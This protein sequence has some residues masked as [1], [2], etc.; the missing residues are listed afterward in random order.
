MKIVLYA[1]YQSRPF[2]PDTLDEIGLG[3]TEQCIIYLAYYLTLQPN[4]EVYVVGEVISGDYDNVKYRTTQEFKQEVKSVDT[5]IAASYIHYLKEFEDIEFKNSIFWVHNTDY[6]TW[7]NGQD[8][9]NHRELLT[10]PKL[11]TIICLTNWHKYKFVEQFPETFDRIEVI[12]NGIDRGHFVNV[13]PKLE[14]VNGKVFSNNFQY[15]HLKNSN[16]YVYTSHCERGLAKLLE[17]WPDIKQFN[18][19][20]ILKISTPEYGLEYYNLYFKELVDNLEDVEFLGTLSRPQLYKLM[21]ES[22]YWYYPSEYEE[23]FCITALEMLG[24]KVQPITWE[25]GGLKETLHG[26]NTRHENEKINWNLVKDYLHYNT[27]KYIVKRKWFPLLNRLNMDLDYFYCLTLQANNNQPL[28]DKCNS[29]TMPK[30]YGYWNK[31]GFDGRTMTPE[32]LA[33]FGVKKHPRWK[34]DIDNNWWNREVTDGEV[35]CALS[36]VD[37]WVDAYA[38]DMEITMILEED[39]KQDIE[40]P[41]TQV[42]QLLEMGY[43]LIYLGRNALKADIEQPIDGVLGWVNPD[44]TYNSHAY[45][46]S[47]RGV[48]ILVEEYIDQYKNEIFALDE[49]LSITFGMTHRQDILLE[50]EGKTRLKAAAPI[51]NYFVQENSQGI[52]NFNASQPEILQASNWEEWCDKYINPHMRKGQYRLMVDEIGPNVIEFPLFTEKFCNEIIELAEQHEWVTDRHLYYPTTDQTM[53]S[54][55]MQS[56]YQKV[57]EQFVYPI[58]IWFWELAG[59]D[60]NKLS[61]ENF[62]A[63]YNTLNQGSLDLHHDDSVI[64]LNV[65]LNDDF[66]GGGTYLPKYKTT[67]QPRK[68]GNVMSHPGQITHIH[69]GRP[70]EEGTRYI[71]VTFTKKPQ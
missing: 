41:W 71:L 16:Q 40:V 12:G 37:T 33:K 60:W 32:D 26:F 10:H 39:F 6:Y 58:W 44:Y 57:L 64:T 47:R 49:F 70:V 34:T 13:W 66:K 21:A 67:L 29:V 23:T 19:N 22:S 17:D 48:Q 50:Y 20:A 31:Q 46:L 38:R 5:I 4:T 24:H 54:L 52:S 61:S 35:G 25:W 43:D 69:G 7:W 42:N 11:S 3:G 55:G 8:I 15:V 68:I 51:T 14:M 63:K 36:H 27:W 9:K 1:G 59:E 30:P 45:I 65:R 62:I 28:Y 53:E 18:P 2:N 56:I